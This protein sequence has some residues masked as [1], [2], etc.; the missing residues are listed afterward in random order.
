MNPFMAIGGIAALF[1]LGETIS[2]ANE[3]S[4]AARQEAAIS[5]NIANIQIKENSVRQQAM[6]LSAQRQKI[7]IA[8]Q[9]QLSQAKNLAAAT[10]QGGQFGSGLSGGQAQATTAGAFQSTGINQ[11]LMLG[12][13][14]FGFDTQIDQ[15]KIA[16]AGAQ[17]DLATAQGK[18]AIGGAITNV[19][20][21][22]MNMF[23]GPQQS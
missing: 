22:F 12:R 11:N 15:Q 20:M 23:G 17:S 5:G 6:E 16:M 21:S 4:S 7:E 2:G 10:N 9:V 3:A 1:G 19:G 8:R 14:M 13:E 18:M